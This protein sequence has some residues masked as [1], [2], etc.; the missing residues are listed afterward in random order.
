M[1]VDYMMRCLTLAEQGRGAVEPNP[2]V[3]CVI[4]ADNRIIGEGYH[5]VYGGPHAE[6]NA[7]DAVTEADKALLHEATLYVSL[8]PCNHQGKTPPCA[9]KIISMGIRHV[10]IGTLDPNPIVAGKGAARLRSAGIDVEV[11]IAEDAC[12]AL[13]KKFMTFHSLHRPFI[14]LKWAQSKDGFISNADRSPVHLSNAEADKLVHRMR[15][16]HMA[17]LVGARTVI[18][19]NPKLTTRLVEGKNPVRMVVD[20][21]GTLPGGFDVFDGTAET[22]LFTVN[23]MQ[24]VPNAMVVPFERE[25]DHMLQ[26]AEGCYV[27]QIQSLLVEG[28]TATIQEFLRTGMWDELVV[29]ESSITLGAGIAAPDVSHIA[30]DISEL[31]DNRILRAVNPQPLKLI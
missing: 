13:N 22:I 7:I 27:Q 11:G 19:D 8:E 2:M 30:L 29:I 28:G 4:V 14:T 26:I 15:A 25:G 10:V 31:G 23:P 5:M 24:T 21:H 3:G 1:P 12:R 18:S 17:I 20:T 9:E 6:V 16:D